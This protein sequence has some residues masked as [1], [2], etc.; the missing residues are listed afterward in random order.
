[1]GALA[2]GLQPLVSKS[3]S[4]QDNEWWTF[5]VDILGG[6]QMAVWQAAQVDPI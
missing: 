6:V 5:S 1:M 4:Y 2:S 3:C